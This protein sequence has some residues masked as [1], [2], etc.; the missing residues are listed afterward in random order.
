ME[1]TDTTTWTRLERT[2]GATGVGAAVLLFGTVI[3]IGSVGEP[4]LLAGTEEAARF[5]READTAWMQPVFA[6]FS[7]GMLAFLWFVVGLSLVLP[8]PTRP[9]GRPPGWCRGSCSWRTA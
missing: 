6:L 2:T 3:A 1:A 5:F 9:G 8:R 4:P 7:V